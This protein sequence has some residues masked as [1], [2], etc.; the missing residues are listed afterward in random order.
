[1]SVSS[2]TGMNS[3]VLNVNAA[4]TMTM[5]GCV[6]ELMG[7]CVDVWMGDK[8]DVFEF[9]RKDSDYFGIFV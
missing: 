9:R 8:A 5:S 7:W 2:P 4:R 6:D 1:M 3:E